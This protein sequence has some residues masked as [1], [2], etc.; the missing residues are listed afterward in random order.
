MNKATSRREEFI[1]A[2]NPRGVESMSIVTG[3]LT[4]GGR[5][6]DGVVAESFHPQL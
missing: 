6:G 2:Y 1:E 3:S 4:A 5:L